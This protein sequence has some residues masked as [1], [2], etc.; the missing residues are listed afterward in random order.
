VVSGRLTGANGAMLTLGG[1][2]FQLEASSLVLGRGNVIVAN[3]TFEAGQYVELSV[4]REGSIA[5]ISTV[6][7]L[8]D[9]GSVSTGVS[10]DR[11]LPGVFTLHGNYPNP[12]NPTTTIVFDLA[13]PA[14]VEAQVFDLLGRRV[15]SIPAAAVEA[16]SSRRLTVDAGHLPSGLYLYQVTANTSAGPVVQTGRMLLLK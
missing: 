10:V 6:R 15:L 4:V 8:D 12:F 1:S 2:T 16:G 3:A 9:A 14:T 11:T 7:L 13:A 5:I